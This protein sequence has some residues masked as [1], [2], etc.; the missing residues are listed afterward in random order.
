MENYF[1]TKI[2]FVYFYGGEEFEFL[3]SHLS[4]FGI[5]HLKTL[6]YTPQHNRIVERRLR[7]VVET[8]LTLLNHA[9]IPL[10]YW[11]YTFTAAVIL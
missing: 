8:G 4:S 5:Q 9:S 11:T 1:G 3:T 10:E 2:I 7:T 6:P